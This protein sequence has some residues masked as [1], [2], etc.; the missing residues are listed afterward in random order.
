[1]VF[2]KSC[3]WSNFDVFRF[4]G[5]FGFFEKFFFEILFFLFFY[6]LFLAVFRYI[7]EI[8]SNGFYEI[9]LFG[10]ILMFFVFFGIFGFFENFFLKYVFFLI[11]FYLFLAVF[12]YI[13]EIASNGFYEILFLV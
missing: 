12:R 3:F 5:I 6:Y 4:F 1:M 2:M 11:F 7:I 8:A 9:L 13:I 10:L